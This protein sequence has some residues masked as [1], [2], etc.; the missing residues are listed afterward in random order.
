MRASEAVLG[1]DLKQVAG[2]FADI[3][4]EREYDYYFW[5]HSD[6]AVM[7]RNS[8]ASFGRDVVACVE[9]LMTKYPDWGILYF[10]YDWFSAIRTDLVR[11]VRFTLCT[12][13]NPI[14]SSLL[15]DFYL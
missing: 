10:A 2:A 13:L 1:V 11:Q 5:G 14:D 12:E 9:S 8:S 3:A 4:I 6:V 7:G 15:R